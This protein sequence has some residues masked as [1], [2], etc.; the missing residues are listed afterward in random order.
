MGKPSLHDVWKW[1]RGWR[2]D[3]AFKSAKDFVDNVAIGVTQAVKTALDSPAAQVISETID[4]ALKTHLAEDALAALKIAAMQ[5]LA[6]EL[7]I[8]GLPNNP[9]GDDIQKFNEEVY[10]AITG[11][12]P[13]AQSKV[14]T[15]FAA[16]LYVSIH[17]ALGG[18]TNLTFAEIVLIIENAYQQYKA[19]VAANEEQ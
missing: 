9:T 3:K 12:D 11:K 16:Q 13:Q 18:A 10:K 17:D 19:D 14:W 2:L 1:I 4:E 6:V 15:T 5:A 8:Q 7:A